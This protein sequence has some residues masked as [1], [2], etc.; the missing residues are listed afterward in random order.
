MAV[1]IEKHIAVVAPRAGKLGEKLTATVTR[2]P[3]KHSK[4]ES[5]FPSA[6]VANTIRSTTITVVLRNIINHDDFLHGGINE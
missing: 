3:I 4:P 5:V 6:S 1:N 2:S